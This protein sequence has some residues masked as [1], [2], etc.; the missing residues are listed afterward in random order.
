MPDA[1]DLAESKL[2]AKVVVGVPVRQ[3]FA[4]GEDVI[5]VQV[6]QLV[7]RPSVPMTRP[8]LHGEAGR[9]GYIPRVRVLWKPNGLLAPR[10]KRS[11]DET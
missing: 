4:A 10:M 1:D 6:L 8:C 3:R 11:P 2:S 7:H 5:L 9:C